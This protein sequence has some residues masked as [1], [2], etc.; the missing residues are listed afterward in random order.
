[1][2]L[3]VYASKLKIPYMKNKNIFPVLIL[4]IAAT[5]FIGLSAMVP[6][7]EEKEKKLDLGFPEEV[8]TILENSCVGCHTNGAKSEKALEKLNF[9]TWNENSVGK[10]I[11]K[12]DEIS[13]EV[14]EKEMPPEKFLQHFPDKKLSDEQIEVIIKWAKAEGEKLMQ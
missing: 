7:P 12:L 14:R 1:M 10:K 13:E 9:S 5:A 4:A 11:H 8:N 3:G 2:N 6:D